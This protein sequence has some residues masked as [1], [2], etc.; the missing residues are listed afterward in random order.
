LSLLFVG[1]CFA[2]EECGLREAVRLQGE[3]REVGDMRV[4]TLAVEERKDVCVVTAEAV[5]EKVAIGRVDE[6]DSVRG[7]YV[8]E[9]ES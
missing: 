3:L 7:V 6:V 2:G 8:E 9:A 1:I 4:R 5:G